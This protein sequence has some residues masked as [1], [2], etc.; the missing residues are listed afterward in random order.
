MVLKKGIDE[1]SSEFRVPSEPAALPTCKALVGADPKS[2]VAH[3]EQASNEIVGQMVTLRRLP[4][5]IPDAIEAKQTEFGSQ[6]EITI[7]RLG[8]GGDLSFRKPLADLPRRVRVLAD[9]Q[10]RIQ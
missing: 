9:V 3:D 5:D 10:R 4:S 2:P 7:R 6:P 8:N 1:L